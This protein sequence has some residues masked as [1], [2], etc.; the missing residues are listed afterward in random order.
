MEGL[1]IVIE[2]PDACGKT[3]QI[4]KLKEYFGE[5][6]KE[7]ILTR[8]PGGTDI[9]EKIRNL[10]LDPKNE[11]M[12]DETEALLYAASRAQHYIEKI[13]PALDEGKVVIC[14]RFV[15]SSLVYQGYAR[16]LGIERVKAINDFALSGYLPDLILYFDI[17][18][19]TA[20]KRLENRG[21]LDRL[22]RAGESF[23][24]AI[25]KGYG[26]VFSKYNQNVRVIDSSQDID[27]VFRDVKRE[28]ENYL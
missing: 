24:R 4:E 20:C 18:Y 13:K 7:I 12:A 23:H 17:D 9:S 11:S 15:H 27:D 10:I 19:E 21:Q 22:E 1:F 2:G 8:E 5:L 14:D 28:I 26:E 25:Y 3:T 16:G 6:D